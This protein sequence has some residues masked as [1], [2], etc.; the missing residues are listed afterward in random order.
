MLERQAVYIVRIFS[1]WNYIYCQQLIEFKQQAVQVQMPFSQLVSY[2]WYDSVRQQTLT[3]V[4][5][6]AD[7][8]S[9]KVF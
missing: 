5:A 2:V 9:L 3:T 6:D 1:M 4:K 8:D 7:D